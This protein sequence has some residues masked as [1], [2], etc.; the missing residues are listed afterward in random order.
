[1]RASWKITVPAVT[2]LFAV[3]TAACVQGDEPEETSTAQGVTAAA[4]DPTVPT[5]AT[6]QILS[7]AT[8]AKYKSALP[9]VAY[10]KLE[11][12]FESPSTVWFDKETMIPSYQDSVGDGSQTPIGARANSQ[13]AGVIVPQGRRLF[14]QDGKTWAFPFA[15]TAGTDASTNIQIPQGLGGLGVNKWTWTYPKGTMLGE[16]IMIKDA[17]GNLTTS[18]IRIRMRYAT[19]WGVNVFRPFPTAQSLAAAIKTARPTWE[20]QPNL[21]AVVDH[22]GNNATLEPKSQTSPG[23]NNVFQVSGHLD[24]LPDFQDE[25]LVKELM[26]KTVFTSAYGETWKQNGTQ[27]SFAP[28]SRGGAAIVP[29]NYEA[30]LL[31][32]REK[33]CMECHKNAGQQIN[34]FETNAVLYGDI[35]GEDGI[36]SFHPYDQTQYSNFNNEN[37][38]VRPAYA[39]ANLVVPYNAGTHPADVYTTVNY[40]P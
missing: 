28:A 24:R 9:K 11:A 14:S 34:D 39:A 29:N 33:M 16:I 1:M 3:A 21:K 5:G 38:R 13:G 25:A 36:F 10:P 19:G 18:E 23:F 12:I 35:W 32:V 27:K 2:F 6:P 31:E 15:H 22:L 8:L 17:Q 20:T 37:R 4:A 26:T 7:A 40:R 30:G